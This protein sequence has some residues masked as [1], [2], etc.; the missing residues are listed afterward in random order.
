MDGDLDVPTLDHGA[1]WLIPS[2][3]LIPT[4]HASH[5]RPICSQTHL[6]CREPRA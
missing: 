6:D 5:S 1:S 3:L 4:P 2:Q